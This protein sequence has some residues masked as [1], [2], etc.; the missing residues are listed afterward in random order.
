MILKLRVEWSHWEPYQKSKTS[1]N[2][3]D[4]KWFLKKRRALTN[5]NK[6]ARHYRPRKQQVQREEAGIC[7]TFKKEWVHHLTVVEL[8]REMLE[9]EVVR[10]DRSLVFEWQCQTKDRWQVI[11][12]IC[13]GVYFLRG[14]GSFTY[15]VLDLLSNTIRETGRLIF[16]P[17]F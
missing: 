4:L 9:D 7:F 11:E 3:G 13:E 14:E 8:L 15:S 10:I 6:E 12:E 17:Q 5:M 16:G 2:P 1:W